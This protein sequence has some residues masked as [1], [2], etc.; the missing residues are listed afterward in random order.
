MIKAVSFNLFLG[1]DDLY[2]NNL[3]E[4]LEREMIIKLNFNLLLY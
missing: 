2:I 3:K 1:W 4:K